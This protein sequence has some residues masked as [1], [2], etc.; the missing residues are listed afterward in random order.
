LGVWRGEEGRTSGREKYRGKWRN[1]SYF[2]E[3]VLLFFGYI[4]KEYLF[5]E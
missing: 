4:L 3:G 5:G 2:F 1:L